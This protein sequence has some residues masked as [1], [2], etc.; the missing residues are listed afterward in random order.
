MTG[1]KKT[2]TLDAAATRL[3]NVISDLEE[4]VA[5]PLCECI[6]CGFS[7]ADEAVR[8]LIKALDQRWQRVKAAMR[9]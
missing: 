8:K 9:R 5:D 3:L 2:E 7:F 1:E 6:A 4:T